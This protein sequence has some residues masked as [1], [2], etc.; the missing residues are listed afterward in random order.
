VWTR[1]TDFAAASHGASAAVF[2]TE[3]SATFAD[4]AWV[5]S[6]D[7]PSDVVGTDALTFV[8]FAATSSSTASTGLT[9]V[10]NDFRVKPGDGI[11]VTSNSAATNVA[12]D[13]TAPGL[14][15]TGASPNG[16]LQVKAGSAG[17]L[18]VVAG[19]V[20]VKPDAVTSG[21]PTVAVGANGLR[22]IG[23]PSA[24]NINGSAVSANVTHTNLNTLTAGATSDASALH[25][26]V[27][28]SRISDTY[29]AL[30]GLAAGDPVYQSS[31]NDEVGKADTT[32][33][34]KSFVIGVA[35]AAILAAASGTIVAHGPV[36][37]VLTGATAG[38][39]YY[40]AVGGGLS[41]S[42]PAGGAGNRVIQ[43]GIAK[44]A[45]DLWVHVRDYGKKA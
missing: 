5:C 43:V 18:E 20:N 14:Q 44:N 33:D 30:V 8:E 28:S 34:L 11:E 25:K 31:T 7:P 12:L 39:P 13:G 35:A 16:R 32:P 40:L 1:P 26:H 17:G 4:T 23:L 37:G 10:G 19:G 41:T 21:N 29:T 2:I 22:V 45:T 24:F 42:I 15:F 36:T 38:T 9:K 6:S 27:G 3:G